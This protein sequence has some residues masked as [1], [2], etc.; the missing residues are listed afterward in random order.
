MIKH[1]IKIHRFSRNAGYSYKYTAS[2]GK[3]LNR[4]RA[5]A[6]STAGLAPSGTMFVCALLVDDKK[7]T[8]QDV[9]TMSNVKRCLPLY[10]I[11]TRLTTGTF[12]GQ[13][14]LVSTNPFNNTKGHKL[15]GK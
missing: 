11:R 1:T 6:V 8:G 14:G 9:I 10:L 7:D 4:S 2:L 15:G 3:G 13:P 12:G 5:R